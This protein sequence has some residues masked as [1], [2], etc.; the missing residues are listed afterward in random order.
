MN[1]SRISCALAA[2][3]AASAAL[4]P[5]VRAAE[6]DSATTVSLLDQDR[7]RNLSPAEVADHPEL[8]A[9]WNRRDVNRDGVLDRQELGT[10]GTPVVIG[11][12]QSGSWDHGLGRQW[13]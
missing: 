11:S 3:V 13:R 4:S 5:P 2:L 12:W 10:P 8:Q 9:Q 6:P 7:D 1:M